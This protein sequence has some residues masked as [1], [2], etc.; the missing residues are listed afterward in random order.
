MHSSITRCWRLGALLAALGTTS[1]SAV[2][3]RPIAE[4]RLP[5]LT[6]YAGYLKREALH[7][8]E[9]V[10]AAIHQAIAQ[11]DQAALLFLEQRLA[12]VIGEDPR[13]A[14]QVVEWAHA[15]P[16]PEMSLYLRAVRETEAV[17]APAVVDRLA[18][19]AESHQDPGHQAS[20]LMA[21][22]TQH[23]FE[24]PMLERLTTLA[25]K[26]TLATG[27][28]MHTVRTIGRVMDNDFQRTGRFE[29]YMGKLLEVALDSTEPDVRALAIEMGTYPDARIEGQ[30]LQQLAK[31]Q[32]EDPDPDVREMAALA[33]SSGR[34]TQRVLDSFG[35]SFLQEKNECV[36]WAIVRYAVRAAGTRALPL[37]KDFARQDARFRQDYADFKALYDAGQ[38]DFDRVFSGKANHHRCGG[39]EG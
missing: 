24:P 37:L 13:A 34:D 20:A 4:P 30:S 38:V 5:R 11:N 16:D 19:L 33:M 14:L 39:S 32:R 12:E 18:T 8:L 29:P 25:R 17:R 22:E 15:T 26:D 7:G 6:C 2:D 31:L 10:R 1:A 35:E 23:R 36:R 3:E 28:A 27:V 21:L 9:G